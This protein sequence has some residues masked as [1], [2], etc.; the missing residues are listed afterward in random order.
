MPGNT[1]RPSGACPIPAVT[2]L[3]PGIR[4]MS[5]PSNTIGP[6]TAGRSPEIVFRVVRL[7]G[8]VGAD[9]GDDLALVDATA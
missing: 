3:C 9:Q 6:R 7:A 4:L 8:A 2:R 5:S 1:P